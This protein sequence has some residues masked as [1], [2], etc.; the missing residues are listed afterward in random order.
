MAGTSAT[1]DEGAVSLAAATWMKRGEA[2]GGRLSEGAAGE[3]AM[4]AQ[5]SSLSRAF[6]A[7]SAGL[8]EL[9]GDV[10]VWRRGAEGGTGAEEMKVSEPERSVDSSLT[11]LQSE[12]K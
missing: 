8:Y 6:R 3:A 5:V 9:A 12:G 2:L 1:A 7:A 10:G 4:T 11:G